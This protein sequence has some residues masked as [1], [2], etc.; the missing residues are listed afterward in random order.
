MKKDYSHIEKM[1]N[2]MV[3]QENTIKKLQEVLDNLDRGIK[4]YKA[5]NKYYYS[6]KREEDLK[7]EENHLIP[8]EMHRGVLSE[9][10]VYN[11]FLDTHDAA[12]HMIE[13]ALKLLKTD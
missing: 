6:E 3:S 9:D 7:D 11:L 1:E 12:L 5:L 13:T 2:I 8:E 4:D 10:E